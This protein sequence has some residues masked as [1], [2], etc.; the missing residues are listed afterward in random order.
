MIN[1][2]KKALVKFRDSESGA[3]LVEYGIAIVLAV[4]VG[5]GALVGLAGAIGDTMD[6]ATECIDGTTAACARP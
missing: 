1:F 5:T 2:V 3:T 6:E 4:V